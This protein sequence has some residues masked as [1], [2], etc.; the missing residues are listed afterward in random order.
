M[1]IYLAT[2]DDEIEKCFPVVVQLRSHIKQ[3]DFLPLIKKQM[4]TGYQLAFVESN[5]NLLSVAGFRIANNL[6]WGKYLYI[7]DLVS[8]ENHRSKGAGKK[9]FDWLVEY[10]NAQGCKQLHLD[11][12]VQR[13]QAHSFYFRQKMKIAGYHFL[14]EL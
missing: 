5:G 13:F 1:Q 12:D 2:T 3:S 6:A 14:M 11:S 7:D 10:A 9:L 8:D 4:Q